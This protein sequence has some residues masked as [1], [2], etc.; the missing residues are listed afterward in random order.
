MGPLLFS[1]FITDIVDNISV[2]I[3]LYADDCVLYH[4]IQST[5]DQR[6][7]QTALDRLVAWCKKWQ[8]VLNL[9][10]TVV[11]YVSRKNDN[12]IY[13]YNIDGAALTRVREYKY[14]GVLFS[15]DL[16]WNSRVNYVI[17]KCNYKLYYFKRV[18]HSA[19][20]NTKLLLY[21]SLIC[22][23]MDY[24]SV[25]WDPYTCKD[26]RK[27]ERVQ[28][29][30]VRIIFNNYSRTFN[31]TSA[32]ASADLVNVEKRNYISRMKFMYSIVHGL[33]SPTLTSCVKLANISDLRSSH[34]YRLDGYFARND[35]LNVFLSQNNCA[36]ERPFSLHYTTVT[37]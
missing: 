34:S 5:H 11:M 2:G 17:S 32:L 12:I 37:K 3:R 16:R 1:L 7:L 36:V 33:L 23:V 21:K 9:K 14:L 31:V 30:A 18:F 19:Q 35:C 26:K 20:F 28:W 29:N 25:I 10:K 15:D 27:L 4:R 24:A 6:T 8:M 22:P 13:H